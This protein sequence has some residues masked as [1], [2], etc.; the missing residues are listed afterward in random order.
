MLKIKELREEKGVYQK[1]VAKVVNKTP[2]CICDWE[3]GNTEPN[4]EDLIK[5]ADYFG[6]TIDYLLGREDDVGNVSVVSNLSAKEQKLVDCY[7]SLPEDGKT[8]FMSMAENIAGMYKTAT[9]AATK[10]S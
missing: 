3:K 6:C 1:E 8:A 10:I 9:K 5:L 7:R 2:T 4:V